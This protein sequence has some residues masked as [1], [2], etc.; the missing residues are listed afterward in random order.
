MKQPVTFALLLPILLLSFI[1]AEDYWFLVFIIIAALGF[2]LE[3]KLKHGDVSPETIKKFFNTPIK[4]K[5]VFG[6]APVDD[7]PKVSMSAGILII[8]GGTVLVVLA[9][10]FYFNFIA[11]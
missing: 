1:F 8:L 5:G 4:P 9:L 10:G 6:E 2:L 11:S 3:I 7:S